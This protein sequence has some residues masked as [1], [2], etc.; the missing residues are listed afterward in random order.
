[1]TLTAGDL[2]AAHAVGRWALPDHP[3]TRRKRGRQVTEDRVGFEKT[4]RG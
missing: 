4:T 2:L 1:M 3:R